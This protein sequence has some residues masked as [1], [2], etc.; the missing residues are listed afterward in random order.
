MLL[1]VAALVLVAVVVYVLWASSDVVR[2]AETTVP[3][4]FIVA[5]TLLVVGAPFAWA[6]AAL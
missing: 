3:Y 4:L 2:D 6:V 1:F 5:A